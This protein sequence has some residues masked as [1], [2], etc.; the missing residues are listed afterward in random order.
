MFRN[1]LISKFGVLNSLLHVV[2]FFGR[3]EFQDDHDGSTTSL[4]KENTETE[5]L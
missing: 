5:F 3:S 1:L 4:E 2:F